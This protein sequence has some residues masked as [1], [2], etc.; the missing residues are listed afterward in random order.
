[1]DGCYHAVRYFYEECDKYPDCGCLET[2]AQQMEEEEVRSETTQ[3]NNSEL[4]D[5]SK[6]IDPK[7]TGRKRAAKMFPLDRTKACEWQKKKFLLKENG[8]SFIGCVNGLQTAIHHGPNKD[9]LVNEIGNVWRICI[10]CHNRYHTLIDPDY[11]WNLPADEFYPITL[12]EVTDEDLGNN[13][14]FWL[15]RKVKAGERAI[16]PND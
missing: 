4:K 1:M 14:M 3:S 8:D 2:P 16:N 11:D 5:N 9:T 7:S 13:E 12:T 15:S 6:V 10:I